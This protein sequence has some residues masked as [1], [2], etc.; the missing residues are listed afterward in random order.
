MFLVVLGAL[1]TVAFGILLGGAVWLVK[2]PVKHQ[3]HRLTDAVNRVETLTEDVAEVKLGLAV[4]QAQ[5]RNNGGSTLRDAVD[6]IER[7]LNDH[8][9]ASARD[10][11]R[12]AS[13]L[14][15]H[16]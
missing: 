5:Y 9:V 11:E 6:R 16:V 14:A 10:S 8:L 12:L 15:N 1:L 2:Q 4:V 7:G 3:V 13:H